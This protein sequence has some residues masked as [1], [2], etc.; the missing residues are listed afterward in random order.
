MLRGNC[1]NSR[2]YRTLSPDVLAR[3]RF[4]LTVKSL[5][6]TATSDTNL[7]PV[8]AKLWRNPELELI[9]PSAVGHCNMKVTNVLELS[10]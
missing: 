1:S 9:V 6:Q 4:C 7:W 2:T 3:P 8:C 5:T 10:W